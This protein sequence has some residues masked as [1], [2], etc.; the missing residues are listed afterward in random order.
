[1]RDVVLM[2]NDAGKF[3]A[4]GHL[5]SEAGGFKFSG[6]CNICRGLNFLYLFS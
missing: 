3:N 2:L 1:M 5:I 6:F 4:N